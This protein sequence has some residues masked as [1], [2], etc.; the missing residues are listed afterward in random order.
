MAETATHIILEYPNHKTEI[1][2]CALSGV[3]IAQRKDTLVIIG[4]DP[5]RGT[6]RVFIDAQAAHKFISETLPAMDLA[7]VELDASMS[8]KKAAALSP[9]P[10]QVRIEYRSGE[11]MITIPT[12]AVVNGHLTEIADLPRSIRKIN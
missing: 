9:D 3:G 12:D 6:A 1:L 10:S 5:N 8:R 11:G 7:G 4:E 2:F